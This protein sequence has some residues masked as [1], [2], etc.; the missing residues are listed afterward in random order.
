MDFKKWLENTE[1]DWFN[2][3]SDEKFKNWNTSSEEEPQY[4]P[5]VPTQ[6]ERVSNP[7]YASPDDQ[8]G[9][10]ATPF[11]MLDSGEVVAFPQGGQTHSYHM[12]QIADPRIKDQIWNAY[13]RGRVSPNQRTVSFWKDPYHNGPERIADCVKKLKDKGLVNGDTLVS[14][15]QLY[16]YTV[17]QVIQ[18]KLGVPGNED[19]GSSMLDMSSYADDMRN[20]H[21][22]SPNDPERKALQRKYG[23]NQTIKRNPWLDAMKNNGLSHGSSIHFPTSERKIII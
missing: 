8:R 11:W 9:S 13:Y 17:D 22:L 3:W 6:P 5:P 7:Y 1:P 20:L 18:H 15:P 10:G 2:Q 21:V 16:G 4:A 23:R 12:T 19:R 14:H